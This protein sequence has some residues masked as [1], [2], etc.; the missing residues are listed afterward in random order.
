VEPVFDFGDMP[1]ANGFLREDEF[2]NEPSFPLSVGF[3]TQC[4]L[5]QLTQVIDPSKLFHEEYAFFASTSIRMREHFSR[6]ADQV[7]GLIEGQ[8]DPFV[9][10]IGSN[11]GI[12]LR[13]FAEAG[14]RHLGIEP[15][16]NVAE[17]ARRNGVTTKCSFF[18]LDEARQILQEHGPANATLGANVFS[19]IEDIHSVFGG[20][21]ELLAD[22]GV[23]V[24]EEPYV[25]EVVDKTAYD[26]FYDEHVF[27]FC[28][29]SLD[30]LFARHGLT[31]IDAEVQEVHGGS[32]RYTV[33]KTGAR[34][35]SARLGELRAREKSLGLDQMATFQA[36]RDRV[37]ASKEQLVTLLT[38]L[39]Q[40]GKRVVGYGATSKSTTVTNFC[41]IGPDLIEFIS[42]TTPIK[43]DK[44]SPGTHIPVKPY[45][46]FVADYPDYA[47][48]FAWN[49]GGEIL[50]KE[51]PFLKQGG[52]FITFVPDVRILD[53]P[54][55]DDATQE[56]SKGNK[57]Q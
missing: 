53:Y 49:H 54:G 45:E 28:L 33:A 10:E 13:N 32:M 1:I 20:I 7:S 22:D 42:D 2:K 4:A 23:F 39:K 26:Q 57:A 51:A 24:F 35:P 37:L 46:A 48:L 3:C 41:G 27:Y 6:F 40:E 38:K 15:S 56:E 52:R 43:Q 5:V 36:M 34:H 16:E 11:D 8:T 30:N 44:F 47:V 29:S 14:V 50:A 55:Q 12:M 19:H 17:E 9:V 18:G 21:K 31:I 25:G